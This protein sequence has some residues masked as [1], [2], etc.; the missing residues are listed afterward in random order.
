VCAQYPK[1]LK[2][3]LQCGEN[4]IDKAIDVVGKAKNDALTHQLIDFLMGESTGLPQD[5]KYIFSLHIAL[6][7]YLPAAHTAIIIA[8]QEQELGNYKVAHGILYDTFK[9]LEGR[10][11]KVPSELK[12]NLMLLHSYVLAKVNILNLYCN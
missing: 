1:A 7:N 5:P 12:R 2:L 10:G 9:D 3:F 6:G 11:I 8:R 4:A